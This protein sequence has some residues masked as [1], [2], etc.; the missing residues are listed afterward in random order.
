MRL[1][2]RCTVAVSVFAI[3]A[4]MAQAAPRSREFS[5]AI[6][7]YYTAD[8]AAHPVTATALGKHAGDAKLDDVTAAAFAANTARLHAMQTR[9]AAIDPAKLTVTERDDRDVLLGEIDRTLLQDEDLQSWRHDPNVYV[10]LASSAVFPLM[11]RDVAPIADRL[12]NVIAREA[13]IPAMLTVARSNLTAMPPIFVEVALENAEGAADFFAHDVP[14]AFATGG[15]P[16][17]RAAL[18]TASANAARALQDFHTWLLAAEKT[19]NGDFRLGTQRLQRMLASDLIP[20][21]PAQVLAAGNAQLARDRTD[22]LATAKTIDP[23]SPEAALAVLDRDHPTAATLVPTAQS[24]LAD[25]RRF[26]VSHKIVTLPSTD[27]PKVIETPAFARALFTAALDQPGI[28]DTRGRQAFY[29]VTPPDAKTS[30]AEQDKFLAIF[31]RAILQNI[32]VHEAMPGHFVQ[33]LYQQANPN[34]SLVR[35]L[36][37]SYATTEGWAHY[38]EQM[39]LDQGLGNHDAK[40]HL[41]QL[42]D[43]LLRDCRLVA[44]ISMHTGTMTL[45]QAT[46]LMEKTCFQPKAEAYREA[47]RGTSDPGYFSYTLGKLMILKLRADVQAADGS[48]FTLAHFH[49]RFLAAGLV[50]VPIIRREM[51]G[52]DGAAF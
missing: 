33:Y 29:Y 47:R 17:A 16:A 52:H 41:A 7:A 24:Q 1:F 32:S 15:T 35:L 31:D 44:A 22:F 38:T 2:L 14:L 27:L 40:Q 34:R 9:L 21:T 18:H 26:V 20:M 3:A 11:A 39:M 12:H 10:G 23:A 13:A 4:Q 49:D 36:A 50:P 43:A 51:L 5:Q 30:A 37:G 6:T 46:T 8:W 45:A 19:A 25:L 28:F 42:Q 48:R